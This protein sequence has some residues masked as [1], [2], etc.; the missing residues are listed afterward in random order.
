MSIRPAAVVA[1]PILA[2]AAVCLVLLALSWPTLV[3]R[4]HWVPVAITGQPQLV[5]QTEAAIT[6]KSPD[7]IELVHVSDRRAAVSSVRRRQAV[8]A[9]V[10][11]PARPEVLTASAAGSGGQQVMSQLSD[12]LQQQLLRQRPSSRAAAGPRLAVTDVVPLSQDDP[13]GNRLAIAGLPLALGGVLGGVLLSTALAGVTGRLIGLACYAVAAGLGLAAILGPWYDAL[14]G[15]YLASAAAIAL[16]V[17]AVAAVVIGLRRVFGLAGLPVAALVFILGSVPISGITVPREF[18]P[19]PWSDI[20][21]WF[22]LG[23]G[24]T[25]LRNL[26]YFPDAPTLGDWLVPVV[27]T[28]IGLVLMVLPLRRAVPATVPTGATAN[29]PAGATIS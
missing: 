19:H 9:I 17:V 16:I 26:S 25:L 23:A 29:Q 12:A 13:T 24:G 6:A 1:A 21:Q 4:P 10:L 8:G 15:S 27:W 18:L 20:G 22:P 3:A 5:Q 28:G 11:D 7:A 2:A 14:P